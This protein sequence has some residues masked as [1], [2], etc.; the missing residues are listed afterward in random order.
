VLPILPVS[1]VTYLPVCTVIDLAG[2]AALMAEH[3]EN[4]VRK[5][6]TPSE[7]VASAEAIGEG[8]RAE[9]KKRQGRAGRDRSGKLP[10]RSKGETRDK[11]ATKVGMSGRTLEKATAVVDAARKDPALQPLVEEMDRTGKVNG[12]YQKIAALPQETGVPAPSPPVGT[13]AQAQ[14]WLDGPFMLQARQWLDRLKAD[15]AVAFI[16]D[17]QILVD[18]LRECLASRRKG[19]R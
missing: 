13:I 4:V 17:L 9:A 19:T 1:V 14:E 8:E 6:F 3:D 12:V 16:N 18:G 11:V 10:E 7:K 5:D 15:E 2:V